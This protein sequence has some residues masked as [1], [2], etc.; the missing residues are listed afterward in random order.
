MVAKEKAMSARVRGFGATRG[1]QEGTVLL[2]V[3]LLIIM[4]TGLGLLTMRHT[5]QELR[6]SGAYKD[7]THAVNLAEAALAMMATDLKKSS[8]YY[9][10][11]F[12]MSDFEDISADGGVLGTVYNIPLNET[13][14]PAVENGYCARNNT[15]GQEV[16][17]CIHQL[18]WDADDNGTAGV[19]PWD[20]ANTD[21]LITGLFRDKAVTTVTQYPPVVGPC[22]PG[23]SC[24]DEQNYGWYIFNVLATAEYG[25][26]YGE[27]SSV[28]ER[29]R[30]MGR[31][32]MTVGP[33]AVFGK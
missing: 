24:D 26:T 20:E 32:R 18:S 15:T 23:Y 12:S 28:Y 8:D 31:S 30:A 4:F 9:L 25:G 22:P 17:G 1:G 13:L 10:A 27:A 14:F 33:I 19:D 5:R 7:N 16:P 3:L 21:T 6:S 11:Q 2:V 29:G